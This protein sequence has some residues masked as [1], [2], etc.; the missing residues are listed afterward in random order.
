MEDKN[1]SMQEKLI[2]LIVIGIFLVLFMKI[3]FF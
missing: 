3:M 2:T 1:I